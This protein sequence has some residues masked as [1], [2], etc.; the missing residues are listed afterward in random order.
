MALNAK[1]GSGRCDGESETFVTAP[2][3]RSPYADNEAR[4]SLLVP[5]SLGLGS[6]VLYANDLAQPV[7]TRNGDPGTVAIP[8][9]EAGARTGNSTTDLRAGIGIGEPGDPMFTLQSGKQHAIGFSCKDYGV[10]VGDIAPA[11]ALAIRG[12][13]GTPQ[14][15]MGDEV[16]NAIL[17]PNGGRGGIG[18]GATLQGMA[19]RRLTPRECERLQGFPD[20]YTQVPFRNKPAADGPRYKALGNSMA[21]PVM[22]WIGERIQEVEAHS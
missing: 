5:I 11:V 22:S 15:E 14:I 17:T 19:V 16:A 8:I 20:N 18:V 10:D 2:L 6:D 12:R 1:G 13:D 7:T 4:E 9:L 3:T 21:V